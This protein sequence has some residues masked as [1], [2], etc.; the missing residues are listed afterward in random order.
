[1]KSQFN[2]TLFAVLLVACSLAPALANAANDNDGPSLD[3]TIAFINGKLS[4]C[5]C[6]QTFND[7]DSRIAYNEDKTEE[8]WGPISIDQNKLILKKSVV[9]NRTRRIRTVDDGI[10]SREYPTS[11]STY[12]VYLFPHLL[13]QNVMVK[14]YDGKSFPD[15]NKDDKEFGISNRKLSVTNYLQ[16]SCNSGN[17]R[18]VAENRCDSQDYEIA[19]C[20]DDDAPKL[21][22]A[23]EHLIKL[24]G[25]QKSLF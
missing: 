4:N 12:N 21:K 18:C 11:N 19:V 13:D 16:L 8:T 7:R 6:V 2:H 24:L 9:F 10:K 23:F 3:E 25:G 15:D 20:R 5:V 22:R 17:C 1:M 14:S